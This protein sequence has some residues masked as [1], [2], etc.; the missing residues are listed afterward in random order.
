MAGNYILIGSWGVCQRAACLIHVGGV[1]GGIKRGSSCH[2]LCEIPSVIRKLTP[3]MAPAKRLL[4]LPFQKHGTA[5]SS[6]PSLMMAFHTVFI[7]P[8]CMIESRPWLEDDIKWNKDFFF[9]TYVISWQQ[10]CSDVPL[11]LISQQICLGTTNY[12]IKTV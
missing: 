5:L 12:E 8:S 9:Y 4:L 6:P 10:G 3:C 7:W 2:A 11:V 1:G